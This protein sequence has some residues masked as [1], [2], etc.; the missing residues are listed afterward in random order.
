MMESARSV[1]VD[2]AKD[3]IDGHLRSSAM[4]I[5]VADDEEEISQLLDILSPLPIERVV[6]ELLACTLIANLR[7]LGAITRREIASLVGVAPMNNDSGRRR[8]HRFVIGVAVR[9]VRSSIWPR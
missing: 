8:G 2:V 1:G 9:F 5:A 7:E 6:L 3:R 4:T